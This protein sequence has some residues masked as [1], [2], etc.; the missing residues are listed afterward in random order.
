[1]R[2]TD[3]RRGLPFLGDQSGIDQSSEMVRKRRRWH[4]QFF[5]NGSDR[6]AISPGP[7][8]KAISLEANGIAQRFEL[9]GCFFDFHGNMMGRPQDVVNAYFHRIRIIVAKGLPV[10][11]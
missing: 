11:A 8:K 9:R 7:N 5:L 1:M 3:K 4:D 2:P 10:L 6:Q